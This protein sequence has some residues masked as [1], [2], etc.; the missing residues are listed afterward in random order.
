MVS[1]AGIYV[2]IL[3]D[4]KDEPTWCA[5]EKDSRDGLLEMYSRDGLSEIYSWALKDG[6]TWWVAASHCRL[7]GGEGWR[8]SR[9]L[10]IHHSCNISPF[11]C[12]RSLLPLYWVDRLPDKVHLGADKDVKDET[13]IRFRKTSIPD[14][15]SLRGEK[16]CQTALF[17][18]YILCYNN[19]VRTCIWTC[20][21]NPVLS[22]AGWMTSQG[23][24][25]S[26][27]Y[28]GRMERKRYKGIKAYKYMWK[29]KGAKG[30]SHS[31][32]KVRDRKVYYV[33]M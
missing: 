14:W 20:R 12:Q 29:H 10:P 6:L 24:W 1:R 17:K 4:L 13:L 22:P 31:G 25:S 9:P 23:S 18:K 32:F 3:R 16:T 28:R 19:I 26:P 2:E 15:G 7:H 8:S 5:L 11:K 30:I 27:R 21:S 33:Y